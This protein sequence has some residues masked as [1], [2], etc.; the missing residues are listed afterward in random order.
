MN[1][2]LRTDLQKIKEIFC[3]GKELESDFPE[4]FEM[5]IE[6]IL[7]PTIKQRK[8]AGM[9]DLT[10]KEF[11]KVYLDLFCSEQLKREKIKKGTKITVVKFN[12][13][14]LPKK[15]DLLVIIHEFERK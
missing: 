1:V 3:K 7:A 10:E 14:R 12:C 13:I 2:D 8:N 5:T 9:Y 6:K 15:K 11:G 4:S